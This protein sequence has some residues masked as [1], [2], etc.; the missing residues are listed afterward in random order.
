MLTSNILAN[1]KVTAV[2]NMDITKKYNLNL[3]SLKKYIIYGR[4]QPSTNKG[5]SVPMDY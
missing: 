5:S 2:I 4:Y 1:K 3:L